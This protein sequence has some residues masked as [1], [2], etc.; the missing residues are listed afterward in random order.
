MIL[1]ISKIK[2]EAL[3]LFCRDLINTYKDI[4]PKSKADLELY[5][6]FETINKE[7]L[8][9]LSNI[10]YEPK[11]YMENQKSFRVRA[12][13]KCYSFISKELEKNLKQNEEFNPSLLY[14]SLLALWFK[15]LGKEQSSKEFI[16]FTLYPYSLIYDRFLV[17]IGDT[18]YKL[19][20]IKMIDLSEKIVLKYDRLVL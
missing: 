8:K 6:E 10:L 11:Y 2:T 3:L 17:K 16:F 1:N 14:F 4:K 20:N 12:I 18:K 19:M 7:I 15:E 9:Q 5:Y 13:L